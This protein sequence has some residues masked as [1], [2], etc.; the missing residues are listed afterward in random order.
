MFMMPK[1]P[2]IPLA[3]PYDVEIPYQDRIERAYK[4]YTATDNQIYK[5]RHCR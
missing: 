1:R 3:D 5:S 4:A 2:P